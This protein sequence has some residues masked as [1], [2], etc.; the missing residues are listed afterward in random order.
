MTPTLE[1]I[2]VYPVKSLDPETRDSARL[3]ERGAL[4]GDREYA[5]VDAPADEPHDRA[6]ASVSGNGDYINGKRT[7]A[8]HRLRSSFDS[9]AGTL[10]L[11]V[12][13][14]DDFRTF[15]LDDRTEL[16]DWLSDYFDRPVSV[17]REPAGGYPDDDSA[18]GP[19]VIST[20]TLRE[21][22]SWFPGIGVGEMRRR[23]RASLEIGGVPAFW[24]DR[25]FADAGEVVAFEIGDV[26][27]A[28]VNPCARCVVPARDPDTGEETPAFRETFLEKRAE[29][30]PEWTDSD[31]FDHDY[32]LM[33]NTNVPESEWGAEISVGDEVRIAGVESE[34]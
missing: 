15:D 2:T 10:T 23:F 25:L 4:A 34:E 8:V 24:E 32:R 19:T 20:G 22:A 1:R 18:S 17:R 14:D 27:F 31:R 28:G 9:E 12:E 16:N 29:T 26:R 6:T 33:V 3:T 30:M 21:V 11:R 13:G 7:A 5:I